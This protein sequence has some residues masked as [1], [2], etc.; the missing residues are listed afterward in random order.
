VIS[1]FAFASNLQAGNLNPA[2]S[3]QLVV[4]QN[5]I[6]VSWIIDGSVFSGVA[7]TSTS[8]TTL[9]L[10][11]VSLGRPIDN[12]QV[13]GNGTGSS[14][15]VTGNGTGGSKLVTGNGTGSSVL[16]TGNGTGGSKLVTG[17]GSGISVQVTGNGTGASTQVTGN[18]TGIS[19]QVTGN[20]TGSSALVT[21]NGTGSTIMVTGSGTGTEAIAINLPDGTGLA[22]EISLRCGSADVTVLDSSFAP[23]VMFENVSVVGD[24][25]LCSGSSGAHLT[26]PGYDFISN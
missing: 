16:V 10:T 25:G 19:A 26:A 11:E 12:T 24:T 21:G 7:L 4:D 3:L 1:F 15:L 18:G 9:N 6:A 23:V 17:N 13:T 22:M 5:T 8:F 20:G 14:V 2:G